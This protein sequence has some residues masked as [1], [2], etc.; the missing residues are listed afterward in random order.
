MTKI[1]RENLSG[2]A[3]RKITET[4]DEDEKKDEKKD[5]KRD[6]KKNQKLLTKTY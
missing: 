4:A 3:R 5:E 2:N 1:L 6:E